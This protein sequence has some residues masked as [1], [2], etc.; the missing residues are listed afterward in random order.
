MITVRL[1]KSGLKVSRIIL[2]MMS[3]GDTHWQPWVLGEQDAVEHVKF[4]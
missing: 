3:Y 1:G 2:G 4:A